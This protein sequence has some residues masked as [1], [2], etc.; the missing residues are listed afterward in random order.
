MHFVRILTVDQIGSQC[1]R[2]ISLSLSVRE[3]NRENMKIDRRL[4]HTK[5]AIEF[6]QPKHS[7][8]PEE[9]NMPRLPRVD[10]PTESFININSYQFLDFNSIKVQIV[11]L[12]YIPFRPGIFESYFFIQNNCLSHFGRVINGRVRNC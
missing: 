1:I 11:P 6:R 2:F 10:M 4:G 7:P 12:A 9:F 3:S 5:P 8:R